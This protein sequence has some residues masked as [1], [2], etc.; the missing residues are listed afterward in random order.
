MLFHFRA[1]DISTR[2][3]SLIFLNIPM[4]SGR[5]H[6][7]HPKYQETKTLHVVVSLWVSLLCDHKSPPIRWWRPL[8]LAGGSTLCCSVWVA[9]QGWVCLFMSCSSFIRAP[10]DVGVGRKSLYPSDSWDQWPWAGTGRTVQ[11]D[12]PLLSRLVKREVL[13]FKVT[14]HA[15]Y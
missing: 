12:G 2:V 4:Q 1:G 8:W 14:Q 15:A 7:M 11:L 9:C 13:L 3:D 10:R 6:G 5:L